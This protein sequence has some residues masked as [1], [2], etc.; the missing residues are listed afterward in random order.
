MQVKKIF[1]HFEFEIPYFSKNTYVIGIDEVGRG[2]L[3]GPVHVG[4]VCFGMPS[5]PLQKDLLLLKINDSKQCTK[6]KRT[7][8]SPTIKEKAVAWSIHSSPVE[9]INTKG[10]VYAIEHAAFNVVTDIMAGLP[11]SSSVI[12]F[13]DTLP[14][15]ALK[16]IKN[17][18]QEPIHK[19]D[20]TSISIAAAS[21]IA[22]VERDS[23]MDTFHT[24][25]PVYDWDT[26]K[27]YATKAHREAIRM[28]GAT[29]LHR[30]LFLRKIVK[31]TV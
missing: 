5:T 31:N 16:S 26:N 12:V 23:I 4:G 8:L 30:S 24:Q 10:I 3:A 9:E 7:A 25:F 1:P 11:A 15:K 14:V 19:G 27:G 21:I 2:C 28:H 17:C 29:P 22:K 13:T 20:C 6:M 18:P